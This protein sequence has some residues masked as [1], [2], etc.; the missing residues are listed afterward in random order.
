MVKIRPY[1]QPINLSIALGY[2]LRELLHH[3]FS[4][5]FSDFFDNVVIGNLTSNKLI[6][7]EAWMLT[8][9]R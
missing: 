3:L 8:P 7:N 1:V 4:I 9:I 6:E 5:Q 2:Y